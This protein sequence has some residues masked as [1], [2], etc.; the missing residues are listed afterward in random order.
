VTCERQVRGMSGAMSG[1]CLVPAGRHE[2]RGLHGD[3]GLQAPLGLVECNMRPFRTVIY[4]S[5][6]V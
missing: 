4:L 5:S 2:E 6:W 1:A 3:P